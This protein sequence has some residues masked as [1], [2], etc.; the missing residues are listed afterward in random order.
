MEFKQ[1]SQIPLEEI[2]QEPFAVPDDAIEFFREN[3]FVKLRRV[4]PEALLT[5]YADE[6][7]RLVFQ[8]N[9]LHKIPLEERD[10]YQKAFLQVTNLW[11]HSEAVR[12]LTLSQRLG[13]IATALMG[14]RGVRLYHDQ[15]LYKEPGGGFT[16]WHVDQY[17]WPLA[18]EKCCTVWIPLQPTDLDMGALAF[19]AETHRFEGGRNIKISDESEATISQLLHQHQFRIVQ[20]PYELGEVSFHYGWTYHRAGPNRTTVPRKVM[21]V[22]YM[23]SEMRL[24]EPENDNQKIDRDAFCPDTNPG[25]LIQTSLNPLIF[26]KD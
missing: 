2:L 24:K 22:I 23:D 13:S 17:Y 5:Y 6:I 1:M 16:P 11:L 15:A 3:G 14:T 12:K 20:E 8:L 4:L 9:D 21:T 19:A 7:T 25:E 26:Q 18:S 10:T